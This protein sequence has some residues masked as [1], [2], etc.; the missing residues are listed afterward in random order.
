M[1]L[2]HVSAPM[3]YFDS[4][5]SFESINPCRSFRRTPWRAISQLQ[6]LTSQDSTPQKDTNIRACIERNLNPRS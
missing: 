5:F 3:A 4:E 6:G 2:F 1:L